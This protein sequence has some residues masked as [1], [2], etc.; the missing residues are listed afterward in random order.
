LGLLRRAD[1]KLK[2]EGISGLGFNNETSLNFI[3]KSF[4]VLV[5]TDKA[6]YKPGDTIKFRVLA[7]DANTKPLIVNKEMAIHITDA[8]GNRIKQWKDVSTAKGVYSN[9]LELSSQPVLGDWK[10]VVE[11]KEVETVKMIEV[12]EYVLPKFEVS[13]SAPQHA[14]YKNG[15]IKAIVRSKYTYGKPVKGEATVSIY[16]TLYL[17]SVQPFIQGSIMR[18]V[19]KIDGKAVVEFDVKEDLQL[20]EEYERDV[21]IEAIVEEELTGRHQNGSTKVTLNKL[22]YKID[23]IKEAEEYKPGLPYSVHIKVAH[24]DGSPVTDNYNKVEVTVQYSWNDENKTTTEYSLDDNGMA[25]V[26]FSVP[27]ESETL[28]LRAKYLEAE[29]HLGYISRANSESQQYLRAK[30][31][32]EK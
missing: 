28:Q 27:E 9:E 32:T 6:I 17:G 8:K 19:V 16:P 7:L 21:I 13:V 2:A 24:H 14:T 18:K 3:S 1:Y 30:V 22:P 10:I 12:A 11:Y 15:K 26:A 31:L 29:F 20:M 4:S 23:I 5:Q 25:K